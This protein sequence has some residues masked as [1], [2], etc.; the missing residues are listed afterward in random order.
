MGEPSRV[1]V[2]G[3][4]ELL[5]AGFVVELEAAG[6][7]PAAAAVQV[8]AFA[9]L[10]RWMQDSGVTPGGLTELE[11]E[12][13][14]REH[15]AHVASVRGAGT[16]VVL[17]YL[18]GSGVV[19]LP[20]PR[21]LTPADELLEQYRRYLTIERA[22]TAGTVRGYVDIVRPFVESR[23]SATGGIE[24]WE[25]SPAD[26]LGFLL[27]ETGRRSRKSAQLLVSALRSLL[28]FWHVQGLIAR[29][30]AGAVPSV[31]GWRLAGLPRAL[32]SEQVRALLDS[33]DRCTV[34][35]IRDFAIYGARRTM[36]R[37]GREPMTL[38]GDRP[39]RGNIVK[40]GRG[41]LR[42][43]RVGGSVRASR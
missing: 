2:T 34:P 31:A 12:R 42:G 13:F 19:P 32:T 14:R 3:P 37:A 35:G 4:L 36:L 25:L 24:L 21:A 6:Y 9:H 40:A 10:S 7:R 16:A 22:L 5:A 29:P 27:A 33:C 18:R 20:E 38:G 11:V 1:R 39:G 28:R 30:L 41:T 17:S 43:H 26:V 23:V 8:R 15:A